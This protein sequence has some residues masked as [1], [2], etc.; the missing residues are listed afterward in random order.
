MVLAYR[1]NWH[2]AAFVSPAVVKSG[3]VFRWLLSEVPEIKVCPGVLAALVPLKHHNILLKK[4][5]SSAARN[6]LAC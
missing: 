6:N 1:R 4:L 5:L 2:Q 3:H